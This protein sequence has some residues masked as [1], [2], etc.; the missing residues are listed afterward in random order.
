MKIRNKFNWFDIL[1]IL[2]IIIVAI[3]VFWRMTGQ[4]QSA[5]ATS[6]KFTYTVEVQKVRQYTVDALN[7]SIGS[8]FN[9]NAP[10]R[11]DDMGIL[12][13]VDVRPAGKEIEMANGMAVFGTIPDRFDVTLTLEL[14]GVVNNLGYFAPQLS[15]IGAG[16]SVIVKSKFVQ[17]QGSI[18][19]VIGNSE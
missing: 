2:A 12:Q 3:G 9:M 10:G 18:G 1:I 17:V 19:Q 7:K 8:K 15:N 5:T 16:A 4:V 6:T 14:G 13:K 11:T